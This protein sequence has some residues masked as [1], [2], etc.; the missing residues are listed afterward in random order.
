MSNALFYSKRLVVFL[1]AIVMVTLLGACGGGGDGDGATGYPNI[2]YSGS[3]TAA[4]IDQNNAADYPF[5]VLENSGN[6]GNLPIAA[7]V[8]TQAEGGSLPDS[9]NIQKV[10]N[11]VT[12][13]IKNKFSS[14][15]QQVVG[16]T[17]S[18]TGTCGGTFSYTENASSNSFNGSLVFDRYCEGGLNTYGYELQL[19]GKMTFSGTYHLVNDSPVFDSLNFNIQYL[20]MTFTDGINTASEEFSGSISVTSFDAANNPLDFNV[21][22]NFKYDGKVFK[23]VNLQVDDMA[24]TITGRL[25]H[26]DHGYVDIITTSPFTYMIN[27]PADDTDDQFCNGSLQITGVDSIGNTATID[28]TDY[29]CSTYDICVT[30]DPNPQVCSLGNDWDT[31]PVWP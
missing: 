4:I 10:A 29:S 11:L 20:K 25:Y 7:S 16:A 24:G 6:A 28:F 27:D 18:Q 12:N 2:T 1:F 26:P 30:I 15:V 21:T 8:E 5:V 23:V 3:T 14:N 19:H 22:I 31:A 9:E 13:L 17:T